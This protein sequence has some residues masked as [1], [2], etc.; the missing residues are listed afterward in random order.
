MNIWQIRLIVVAIVALV[1]GFASQS[2][3]TSYQSAFQLQNGDKSVAKRSFGEWEYEA[4]Q[5]GPNIHV[6][7]SSSLKGRSALRGLLMKQKEQI[8]KLSQSMDA[9]P[10]II[11][12]A[13]PL[14]LDKFVDLIHRHSII[15]DS[16]GIL[17]QTQAKESHMI[18]GAPEGGVLIPNQ[19]LEMSIKSIE[20]R[21]HT[22]LQVLG[23]VA[24][25][26]KVTAEVSATL[27]ANP[28]IFGLDLTPAFAMQDL[29]EK[30]ITVDTSTIQFT[31]SSL[32]WNNIEE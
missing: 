15:V 31:P 23:I 22:A 4:H 14:P 20:A 27:N 9:L 30:H 19:A 24:I 29:L 21:Q 12:P 32:Y 10:V 17:A 6:K 2:I 13:S 26:A 25:Q 7:I 1:L 3:A 5:V 8:S 18:F 11:I 28:A 16:Y